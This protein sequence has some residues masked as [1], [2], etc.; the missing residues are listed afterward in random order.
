MA[1]QLCVRQEQQQNSSPPSN[2]VPDIETACSG[3]SSSFLNQ[4]LCGDLLKTA[5]FVQSDNDV[6]F[7]PIE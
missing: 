5:R 4:P 1:E 7:F 2:L 3:T 6:R